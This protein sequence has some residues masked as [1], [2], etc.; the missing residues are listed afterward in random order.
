MCVCVC[1]Q[2]YM[3][4]LPF[5][6]CSPEVIHRLNRYWQPVC[7]IILLCPVGTSA[8]HTDNLVLNWEEH[9]LRIWSNYLYIKRPWWNWRT[10]DAGSVRT[11]KWETS[12]E[13]AGVGWVSGGR[14]KSRRGLYF[15]RFPLFLSIWSLLI[16]TPRP[17][18]SRGQRGV[19][20]PLFNPADVLTCDMCEQSVLCVTTGERT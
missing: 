16:K 12:R 10:S 7:S 9:G 19:P 13:L 18:G 1:A 17:E 5:A 8:A 3:F 20:V 14:I 6:T 11:F 15:Q 2:P 4:L